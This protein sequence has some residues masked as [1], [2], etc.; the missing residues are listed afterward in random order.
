MIEVPVLQPAKK[1]YSLRSNVLTTQLMMEYIQD[2]S[3][4]RESIWGVK[5]DLTGEDALS[6]LG[7]MQETSVPVEIWWSFCRFLNCL[8][9][10]NF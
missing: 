8:S 2:F 4:P 7:S 10:R 6:V 5:S 3:I 1:Q 9:V